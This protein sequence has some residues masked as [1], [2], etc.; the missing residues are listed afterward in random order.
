MSDTQVEQKVDAKDLCLEVGTQLLIQVGGAGSR[1]KSLLVGA[2]VG[3]YLIVHTPRVAGIDASLYEGNPVILTFL[4]AGVVY[5]FRSHILN[6]IKTPARL[7][8]L[9]YPESIERHELR[10]NPRIECNIPAHAEFAEHSGGLKCVISDISMGGCRLGF[11]PQD[12]FCNSPIQMKES[13]KLSSELMGISQ[14]NSL[15]GEVRSVNGDLK[16]ISLGIKFSNNQEATLLKIERYI[17]S[18]LEL[19]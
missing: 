14:E 11:I 13:V 7:L 8:F 16:R 6:Q 3:C 2:E 10:K 19:G 12:E 1:M 4:R 9:A 15:K 18:V 17:Q 5:G